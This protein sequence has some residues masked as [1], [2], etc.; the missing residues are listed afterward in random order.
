MSSSHWDP[1]I[2]I[3]PF[4]LENM[5]PSSDSSVGKRLKSRR[6]T[7]FD[8]PCIRETV[9]AEGFDSAEDLSIDLKKNPKSSITSNSVAQ[10]SRTFGLPLSGL[11]I[12]SAAERPTDAGP[13][14][15]VVYEALFS[16]GFRRIVPS[17][18]AEVSRNLGLSS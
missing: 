13:E 4:V 9:K 17:L 6:A 1:N 12:P 3:V 11:R 5:D 18:V 7:G 15:I 2:A 8:H 10:I 16:Y 14:E